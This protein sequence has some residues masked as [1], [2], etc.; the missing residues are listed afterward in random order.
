VIDRIGRDYDARPDPIK[1]LFY[2][3]DLSRLFGEAEEELH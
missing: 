2:T 3:E 1:Q